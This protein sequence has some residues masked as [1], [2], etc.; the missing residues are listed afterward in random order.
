MP[1]KRPAAATAEKGLWPRVKGWF[2]TALMIAILLVGPA[3]AVAGFVMV[4]HDDD[5]LAHGARTPGVVVRVEDGQKASNR[6]IT[7]SYSDDAGEPLTVRALIPTE[8]HPAEGDPVTVVHEP[9]NPSRA[10]VE[11]YETWGIFFRGVG[12]FVTFLLLIPVVLVFLVK[13]I[14]RLRGRGRGRKATA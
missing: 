10:V 1:R 7:V 14:R 11:G 4:A 13:G 3:F 12:L 2:Y 9:G 6:Q 5:L 8:L